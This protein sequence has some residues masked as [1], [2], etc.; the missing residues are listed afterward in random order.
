MQVYTSVLVLTLGLALSQ[1][2]NSIPDGPRGSATKFVKCGGGFFGGSK[3]CF[4]VSVKKIVVQVGADGT[5]D[6]V[7]VKI[8]SDASTTCC[9][10]PPLKKTFSDDWSRNDLEEWS[11][12]YLGECADKKFAVEKG[13]GVTL[14]KKGKDKLEV[15]NLIVEAEVGDVTNKV[16][17]K[18][19]CGAWSIG[20]GSSNGTKLCNTSAFSYE[21]VD[22]IVVTMG[23]EGTDD[24][25]KVDI[26]SDV[27]DGCCRVKLKSLLSDDWSKNDVETWKGSD[28]GKCEDV[29]YK[30]KNG[31]KVS[32]VKNGK[33]DL[34]VNKVTVQTEDLNGKQAEYD[35]K[36]Y[37]LTGRV[38][39]CG[40][41]DICQQS[42][43]CATKGSL[44]PFKSL[45]TRPTTRQPLTSTT[46]RS[47]PKGGLLA[48]AGAL[49]GGFTRK[50][51]TTEVPTTT[52]T[53]KTTRKP[54]FG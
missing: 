42:N 12:K 31:L 37:T 33:D 48:Q 41:N 13:L 3:S 8:C 53:T 22:K 14:S 19:E 54:F 5:D 10:T 7:T 44:S 49:F 21:I 36:G 25:V 34:I 4:E 18:F 38:K 6:D 52:T 32:L 1:A 20:D 15:T 2:Q 16:T 39:T 30:V 23:N 27:D 11:G 43:T 9:T 47:K 17:E 46:L 29:K 24:D 40:A 45:S 26:C 35:C 50:T 28:L 51:T